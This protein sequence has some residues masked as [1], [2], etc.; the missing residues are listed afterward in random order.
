MSLNAKAREANKAAHEL[1]RQVMVLK[2]NEVWM[3]VP[4]TFLVPIPVDDVSI[5]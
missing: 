2:S 3:D 5:I 1:T 4:P